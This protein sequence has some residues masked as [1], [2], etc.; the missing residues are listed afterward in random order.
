MKD[1]LSNNRK[2]N[3]KTIKLTLSTNLR[4]ANSKENTNSIFNT[5]NTYLE[6]S[7]YNSKPIITEVKKEKKK[8]F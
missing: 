6:E 1:V 8:T 5:S 3:Q 7:V 2:E 4:I